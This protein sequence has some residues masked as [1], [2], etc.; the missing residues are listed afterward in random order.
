VARPVVSVKTGVM[1]SRGPALDGSAPSGPAAGGALLEE[2]LSRSW[3]LTGTPKRLV[4]PEPFVK[5]ALAALGLSV[6]RHA[7]A[8]D[9][10]DA[11]TKALS[12]GEPLVL[13]AFGPGIVHKTEL[14][15]VHLGLTAD[16]VGAA[17]AAMGK[18]LAEV[19]VAP[20][21]FLI[22][23]QA[24]PG[25]ELLVGVIRH[26]GVGPVML[27][28]LGGTLT[29]VLDDVAARL[30]PLSREDATQMLGEFRGSAALAGSR[31]AP[32]VDRDALVDLLLTLAGPEGLVPRLGARLLELECNPVITSPHGAL[33]ADAR[34]VLDGSGVGQPAAEPR[35]GPA[36]ATIPITPTIPTIPFDRLFAPRSIAVAGASLTHQT[37]GNRALTAYRSVGWGDGLWAIHPTATSVEGVPA[38]PSLGDLPEGGVDYL[39]VALPAPAAVELLRR[40]GKRAAVVQVVSGGFAEA[41]AEGRGLEAEL[42]NAAHDAGIRVLGPNCMGVYSPAGRQTYLQGVSLEPGRIGVVSQSGGLGGDLINYGARRGL[43]FS[44]VAS[45]GNAA[46]VTAGEML[47]HLVDDPATGV[48]GLYLEGLHDGERV[49]EAL[50]RL[51]GRKPVV[52]LVGGAGDQGRLAVA[53]HTGSMAVDRRVWGAISTSTGITQVEALEDLV[54]C[55]V[56]HQAFANHPASG[57]PDVLV[58]GV[59]GGAT[60]LAA[61]ACDRAGLRVTA[62]A[63]SLQEG[64]REMGFG[65]GTSVANPI[66]AVVSAENVEPVLAAILGAQVFPDVLLH[67]NV[68]AYYGYGDAGVQP[69]IQLMET[70]AA[71]E[72]G[73]RPVVVARNLDIAPGRHLDEVFT[74]ATRCRVPLYRT[75]DEAALAISAGKR[76]ARLAGLPG[77]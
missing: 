33:V 36:P 61:D 67:V 60:V 43:R 25:V 38:R 12:L 19:A 21:G 59:G 1:S 32:P 47:D 2:L 66:E 65:V 70:L 22:E 11:T 45:I 48:I 75:L 23:Q 62:L 4:V 73:S 7:L 37:F 50:R 13:K 8:H 14:A 58:M 9:A 35:V 55:L 54:G 30:V 6:P 57:E 40:E 56:H 31:G 24:S 5:Q 10:V 15:A 72:L 18:A 16:Q 17:A 53:T 28:G 34:L 27:L 52:A 63:P 3:P 29:E 76:F 42:V 64:L 44:K 49:V 39:Q 26:D 20:Q 71:L 74:A 68:Q 69:L 51:Q 41:G 46:D 77:P